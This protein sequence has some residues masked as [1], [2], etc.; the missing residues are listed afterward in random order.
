MLSETHHAQN[1]AGII[2]LGL[3]SATTNTKSRANLFGIPNNE[4]IAKH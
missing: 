2:G 3:L 1:Y 4:Y